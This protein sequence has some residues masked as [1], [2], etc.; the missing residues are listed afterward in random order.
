MIEIN[1]IEW[2]HGT[3]ETLVERPVVPFADEV[4]EALDALS[5]A[6]MKDPMSR[7]YPDVVTFAF[8]CRRG[9]LLKLREQYT[10]STLHLQPRLGWGVVFHI[11]PSNVPVNFAYSVVAGL[12]AGNTNVVRVSQ[13]Q[14]PQVDIIVKH[15]RATNMHR[16]AVVRY[17]HESNA[18]EVFSSLCNVRVIWGGDATIETIRKNTIPA[19]AFDIC[20]ADRYSIAAINAD[21]LMEYITKNTESELACSNSYSLDPQSARE[22]VPGQPDAQSCTDTQLDSSQKTIKKTPKNIFADAL[23]PL[24]EKFYN[25]TYLFDQNACSAPHLVCW[26]GEKENVK[27]AK[28]VFWDAVYAYAIAHYQFQDVMAVDKLIALYKQAVAMPTHDVETK[29]NVL[30][31]VEIESLPQDID[32]F[33]CAGGYFT[34]CEVQSLDDIA[35]I[36]SAKYQTLAYYGFEREELEA[37]V[38]RNRLTGIDRIVPFGET[39]AFSL[40]WDGR[41]LIQSMSRVVSIL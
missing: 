1:N 5:K 25:D 27:K 22:Q 33:R 15:M 24:A 14:F 28:E 7:Q 11:A 35:P 13:K 3:M 34:E 36:V 16:V 29:D 4:I 2:L 40:T 18:N 23:K 38:Q 30:R 20:F 10:P 21:S 32:S 41:D 8:F 19:R 26:L 31:R 9:N 6:L 12:L 37:F 17:P 39:T